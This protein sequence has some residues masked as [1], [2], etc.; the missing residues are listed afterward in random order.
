MTKTNFEKIKEMNIDEFVAKT[1]PCCEFC[2]YIDDCTM[3]KSC[4]EGMKQY[5]E[6]ECE[7]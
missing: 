3:E 4:E 2:I 1:S 5:L 6:S 7:E